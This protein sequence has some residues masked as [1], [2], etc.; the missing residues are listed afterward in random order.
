MARCCAGRREKVEPLVRCR[1]RLQ[2]LG[3]AVLCVSHRNVTTSG[4]IKHDRAEQVEALRRKRTRDLSSM[5]NMTHDVLYNFFIL[6]PLSAIEQDS[7]T[8]MKIESYALSE[9]D[10]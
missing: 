1:R 3:S 7:G 8:T 9:P 5:A 2:N 6:E 10:K 4:A